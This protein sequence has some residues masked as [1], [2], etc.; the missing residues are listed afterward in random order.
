M[1]S[2]LI[3]QSKQAQSAGEAFAELTAIV[4]LLRNPGGC[5]WDAEQTHTSLRPNL[6]EE[7]YETLDAI[8]S[9]DPKSLA[10]EL[11]DIVTQIVFHPLL[12]NYVEKYL[13]LRF[14]KYYSLNL[15]HCKNCI[16]LASMVHS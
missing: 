10:E 6:L 11:G 7:T 16:G 5:P 14:K 15:E 13:E 12:L 4:E 1:E 2:L 3:L 8:D 9:G